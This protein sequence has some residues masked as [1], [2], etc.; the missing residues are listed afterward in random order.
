MATASYF[1]CK[2][3]A[4]KVKHT[5]SVAG[6]GREGC[7][8][9]PYAAQ[10]SSLKNIFLRQFLELNFLPQHGPEPDYLGLNTSSASY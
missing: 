10:G 7:T 3:L 9:V 8:M 5:T 4:L 1:I 6:K 2:L